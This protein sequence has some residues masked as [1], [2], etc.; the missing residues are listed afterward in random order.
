MYGMLLESVQHFV[1]VG[2]IRLFNFSQLRYAINWPDETHEAEENFISIT[3]LEANFLAN[4]I[5]LPN[6]P[7]TSF[8]LSSANVS[9][10]AL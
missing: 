7:L 5:F 4:R 6:E 1:Q 8:S 2:K 10:I 9:G 3:Q